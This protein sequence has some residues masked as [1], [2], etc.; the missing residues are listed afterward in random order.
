MNKKYELF[1]QSNMQQFVQGWLKCDL[2]NCLALGKKSKRESRPDNC[3]LS[4]K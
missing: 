3:K 2:T 4:W 1:S